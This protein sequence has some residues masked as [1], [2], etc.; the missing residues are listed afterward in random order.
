MFK[1][2]LLIFSVY[3]LVSFVAM[4]INKNNKRKGLK[5]IPTKDCINPLKWM[6]V[7]YGF[8]LKLLIPRHV[9]EQYV[10]RMYDEDCQICVKEGK[11]VGGT[12]CGSDCS[13][14]CD[15]IAK[16]YSPTEK[17]SGDNWGPIIFNKKEYEEL[18]KETPV[19]IT[20]EYGN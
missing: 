10:L 9:F 20:I 13:C 15:T 14:G 12:I 17:D 6:S 18:R 11:C 19:K 4:T 16:M 8:T 7:L 3:L 2:C 5:G 1:F